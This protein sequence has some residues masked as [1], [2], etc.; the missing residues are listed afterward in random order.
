MSEAYEAARRVALGLEREQAVQAG[1]DIWNI[2]LGDSFS[3]G[4]GFGGLGGIP[5]LQAEMPFQFFER[6]F[7]APDEQ[8]AQKG[9]LMLFDDEYEDDR[10]TAEQRLTRLSQALEKNDRES[11]DALLAEAPAEEWLSLIFLDGSVLREK[12]VPLMDGADE[13]CRAALGAALEEA[14]G[15]LVEYRDLLESL[16]Q[17]C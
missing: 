13:S 10:R 8:T 7:E 9:A 6:G 3:P 2:S 5:G 16:R 4:D 17:R 14:I 15:R 11:L 12:L 1:S